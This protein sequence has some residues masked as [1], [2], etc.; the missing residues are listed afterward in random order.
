M[1]S[2]TPIMEIARAKLLQTF[3]EM[4][5]QIRRRVA[6]CQGV[7]RVMTRPAGRIRMFP[8]PRGSNRVGPAGFQISWGASDHPGPTQPAR[9]DPTRENSC[10]IRTRAMR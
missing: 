9:S 2:D 6:K 7:L 3:A 1:A 8:Q 5:P 10:K 4:G